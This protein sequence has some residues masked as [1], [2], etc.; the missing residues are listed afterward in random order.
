MLS[1]K[2]I[3]EKIDADQ[4]ALDAAQKSLDE[5]VIVRRKLTEAGEVPSSETVTSSRS[6]NGHAKPR[7][8]GRPPGYSPKTA[9]APSRRR[10]DPNVTPISDRVLNFVADAGHD[11]TKKEIIDGL[12]GPGTRANHI[13]IAIERHKRGGRLVGDD[14]ALHTA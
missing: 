10:R 6:E 13:G 4:K 3:D 9:A 8:R 1:L 5:W 11:V 14:T 2:Q 12:V 7:P